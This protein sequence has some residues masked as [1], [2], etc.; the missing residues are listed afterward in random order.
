MSKLTIL[1]SIS[2]L[3]RDLADITK[4]LSDETKREADCG[5]RITQLRQS[6]TKHTSSNQRNSKNSEINRK[7]DEISRIQRRKSDLQKKEADAM[8]KFNRYRL[9]LEREEERERKK[10]IDAEKRREREQ[11]S[12]QRAMRREIEAQR[13]LSSPLGSVLSIGTMREIKYDLFISHASEDKD[14]FVRLLAEVLKSLDVRVWY[15]EF[16]LELGDSLRESI[17]RG[18]VNSKYG[19]VVLSPYFFAKNWP[20]YELNGMV[21][22]EMNGEKVI[23]PIWHNV[24]KDEVLEFSPTLADK[25]ALNSSTES[26]DAIATRLADR[27]LK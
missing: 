6:I 2:R 7:Q 17:D 20:Q 23:L 4:K 16:T 26:I 15:D 24:T 21:A 13:Q 10:Q 3:Q 9:D 8:A 5:K 25:V 22:R 19:A 1:N 18:L 11:L 27:V 12:H 14:D